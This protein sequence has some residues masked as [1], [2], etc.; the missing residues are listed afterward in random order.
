MANVYKKQNTKYN[1][2]TEVSLTNI[3][4][5]LIQLRYPDRLYVLIGVNMRTACASV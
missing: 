3:G 5:L 1:W 4:V 2:T